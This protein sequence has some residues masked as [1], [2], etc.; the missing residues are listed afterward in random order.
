MRPSFM[1]LKRVHQ[2]LS[3]VVVGP[4]AQAQG[5]LVDESLRQSTDS[6]ISNLSASTSSIGSVQANSTYEAR[7]AN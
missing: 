2:V 5:Q 3:T 6:F 7:M 1:E 4:A